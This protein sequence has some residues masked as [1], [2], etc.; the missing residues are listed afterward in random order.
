MTINLNCVV[1]ENVRGNKKIDNPETQ[2]TIGK[3][4]GKMKINTKKHNTIS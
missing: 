3:I 1:R 2:A 4:I